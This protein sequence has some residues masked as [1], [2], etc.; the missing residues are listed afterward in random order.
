MEIFTDSGSF[1]LWFS[2]QGFSSDFGSLASTSTNTGGDL[3]GRFSCNYPLYKFGLKGALHKGKALVGV[4]ECITIL[5]GILCDWPTVCTMD[6][7]S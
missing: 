7:G 3:P 1:V 5:A 6:T 4:Y 2:L